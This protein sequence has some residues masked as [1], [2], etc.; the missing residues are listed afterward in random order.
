MR[1]YRI[2]RCKGN[3]KAWLLCLLRDDGTEAENY[4]GYTTDLN[5][6]RLLESAGHLAPKPGD[7]VEF[8]P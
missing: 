1:R 4:G 8:V 5:L 6:D 7:S 3:K 2:R